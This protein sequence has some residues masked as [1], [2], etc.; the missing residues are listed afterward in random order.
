MNDFSFQNPT[1]II[2]G[3]DTEKC[4][5]PEASKYGKTALVHYGGGSVKKIGVLDKVIA[6]LKNAGMTVIELGGVKPNPRLSLVREGIELVKKNNV[7]IIIA[8]GGGSVIDSSK[9]IA[10]GSCYDGDVWD[11]YFK[12]IPA[13]KMLPLGTVLTIPAAGSE[14]SNSSVITNEDGSYKCGYSSDVTYPK[15]SVLNPENTYSLPPYQIACGASDILAHLMERYFVN[16]ECVELTDR[17]LEGTMKN[18]IKFAPL[19]IKNP[20]NYDIRAEVMLTGT[21]AHNNS[22]DVGRGGD[23]ASHNIEHELSGIYDIAHGAGLSI[24]FPAWMKYVRKTNPK[25]LVQFGQRVFDINGLDDE[26]TI[27]A[28]ISALED[29]YKSIG[30]PT[31]LS[32]AGIDEKN[33]EIMAQKA[34]RNGA[35]G[36]YVKLD[37]DATVEIYNIAK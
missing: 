30:V 37:K 35:F 6:S 17:L 19:A 10:L 22:M 5:G 15:F 13:E 20:E 24:I 11:F 26:K 36:S 25:K 2:F 7:D 29:F 21:Y 9:A 12:G 14:S 32:E 34:A 16:V 8:V 31:R 23:W 33:F 1:K 3:K 27:D 4:V 18:I 28:A